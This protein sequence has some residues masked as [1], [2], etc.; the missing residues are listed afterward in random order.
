MNDQKQ[1]KEYHE[2]PKEGLGEK[3]PYQTPR[4]IKLGNVKELTEF[5]SGTQP[6]SVN[7]SLG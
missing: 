7:L 2:D 5:G 6:E 3:K 4:L 1:K